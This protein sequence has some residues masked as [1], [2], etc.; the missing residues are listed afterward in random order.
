MRKII[1]IAILVFICFM[2]EFFSFNFLGR[3]FK[4]NLSLVLI[5]FFNFYWGTRYGLVTAVLSGL[6]KD[7]FSANPFGLNIVSF[8]ICVYLT[9]FIRRHLYYLSSSTSR[10]QIVL[11][12][13]IVNVLTQYS[14]NA[15]YSS[16][17]FDEMFLYLIL[18]ELVITTLIAGYSF[19]K[20]KA[21]V[22][23]VA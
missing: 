20:I 13:C 6:I 3:W 11:I 17:E 10:I 23:K 21:F 5:V 9:T 22:L 4:P 12:L 1:V 15:F 16:I 2:I 14:I 7:S 19:Q 18:P 8:I